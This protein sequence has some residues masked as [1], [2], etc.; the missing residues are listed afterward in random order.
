MNFPIPAFPITLKQAENHL[1]YDCR[2]CCIRIEDDK[3]KIYLI[4][5][6]WLEDLICGMIV[7]KAKGFPTAKEFVSKLPVVEF[8]GHDVYCR[9]AEA[10]FELSEY[11]AWA[12]IGDYYNRQGWILDITFSPGKGGRTWVDEITEPQMIEALA[13]LCYKASGALP[14]WSMFSDDE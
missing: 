8:P 9:E 14:D 7:M 6:P 12:I 5:E 1:K 10:P 4:S 11:E 3:K 2:N 13:L